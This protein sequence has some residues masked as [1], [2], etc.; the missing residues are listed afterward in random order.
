M[1]QPT[2]F[3][4]FVYFDRDVFTP[5]DLLF[6]DPPDNPVE[7]YIDYVVMFKDKMVKANNFCTPHL[8]KRIKSKELIIITKLCTA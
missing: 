5:L 7:N 6:S 1:L 4:P 3:S 2:E 8:E